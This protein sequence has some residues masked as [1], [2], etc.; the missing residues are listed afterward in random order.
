MH[1][2]MKL[3]VSCLSCCFLTN[4]K[5]RGPGERSQYSD[6]GIESLWRRDFQHPSRQAP[7]PTQP[8]VQ[9]VPN[10]FP[11]GKAAEFKERVELY[12]STPPVRLHGL[13]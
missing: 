7:G 5:Y 12:N 2:N 8:P 9:R 10:L 11:K 3:Y 6:P 1:L 4:N 13:L